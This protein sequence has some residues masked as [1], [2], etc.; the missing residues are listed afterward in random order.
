LSL[1]LVTSQRSVE[2]LSLS[3]AWQP[4]SVSTTEDIFE[5][6]ELFRCVCGGPVGHHYSFLALQVYWRIENSSTLWN[7]RNIG[8]WRVLCALTE[9]GCQAADKDKTSTRS[10]GRH[11]NQ[12]Q[13]PS[14]SY[15]SHQP[16]QPQALAT[17]SSPGAVH[18]RKPSPVQVL[19]LLDGRD[20]AQSPILVLLAD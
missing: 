1:V 16:P 8:M 5:S 7:H 13:L 4:C 14:P 20:Y 3:A 19:I 18:G 10:L 6:V 12:R 2:V 11:Q 9:Q 15:S 17:N